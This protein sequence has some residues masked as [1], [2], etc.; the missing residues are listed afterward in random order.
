M[1]E[2]KRPIKHQERCPTCGHREGLSLTRK[3]VG[4]I[5][6]RLSAGESG[7]SLAK[8]YDVTTHMVWKIKTN[9]AWKVEA[10]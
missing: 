6:E 1:T 5:R 4:E 10:A 2:M 3:Q 7:K 8:A 9:K